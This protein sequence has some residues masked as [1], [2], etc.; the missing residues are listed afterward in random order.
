[1]KITTCIY[2]NNPCTNEGILIGMTS[3]NSCKVTYGRELIILS[4]TLNYEIWA[5]FIDNSISLYQMVP[6]KFIISTSMS[7]VFPT[8]IHSI[9]SSLLKLSI[10]K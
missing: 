6:Y 5:D 2:C 10:F 4:S 1:M 8:N 3:C 9:I 7:W